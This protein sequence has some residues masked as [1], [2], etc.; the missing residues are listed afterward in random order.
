MPK[1]V[2]SGSLFRSG[3]ITY[4]TVMFIP[5]KDIN[6]NPPYRKGVKD[7]TWVRYRTNYRPTTKEE[8]EAA[9]HM[10]IMEWKDE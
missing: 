6:C 5:A 9:I 3:D 10:E 4:E 7:W 2:E 1:Y 8:W